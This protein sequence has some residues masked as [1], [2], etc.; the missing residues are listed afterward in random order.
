VGIVSESWGQQQP[1]GDWSNP[2]GESEPGSFAP[3]PVDP[4]YGTPPPQYGGTGQQPQ[5]P[6]QPQPYGGG[7]PQYGA[8]QQP[9]GD[10]QPQYGAPPQYGSP[11]YGAPQYGSVPPPGPGGYGY[12]APP[13]QKNGFAVAGFVLSITSI[14]GIIFSAL[15]LSRASKIGGKGRQLAIAGI[16]LSVLFGVLWGVVGYKVANS[17]ALD[18]GCT[19]AENSFRSMLS[20]IQT[21][22]TKLTNDASGSNANAMQ[23]DLAKF[24]TDVQ[25]IK[26]ALDSALNQAQHQSVKDKIQAMDTDI[27]T[28]LTGLQ[29]IQQGD[30]SQL[31]AFEAAAGRLG[32]DGTALD[33]ICSS[34]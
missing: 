29:S 23:S 31:S 19:A 21:D 12:P 9:Y 13:P 10:Q 24:T 18:P 34:L 33:N 17:T 3:P 7:T 16:V 25:S 11:E 5:Q 28:V 14:L 22:E 8:P 27:N 4:Q 26:S 30:T 32:P 15:G 6:E 2:R 1:G 20:T